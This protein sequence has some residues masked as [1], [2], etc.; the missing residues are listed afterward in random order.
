MSINITDAIFAQAER[1]PD[2][3]AVID[4]KM[5]VNYRALCHGVRLAAQQFQNA[6]W[7]AGNIA[8]ISLSGNPALHLVCVLALARMGITQVSM[9]PRDLAPLR[10][11]RMERLGIT[12]LIVNN[13][14]SAAGINVTTVIPD[15]GWLTAPHSTAVEDIRASGGDAL[16]IINETSGTTATPK[17]IGISHAAEDIHH[18]RLR[19]ALEYLPGERFLSL[20]SLNFLSALKRTI[21]CLSE[22]GTVTLPPA[23]FSTDQLLQWIELHHVTFMTCVPL[24]L[25]QI[26]HDLQG[27]SQCLPFMRILRCS[28][29]TL[30]VSAVIDVCK[31]ISPNVYIDYGCTE[32]GTATIATPAMLEA[33]PG[34]IGRPLAGIEFEVVDDDG[35]LVSTGAHGHVRVRGPGVGNC[36]LHAPEP[37]QSAAFR[38]GWF[39]PGDVVV[40][41][42]DGFV[43]LKGRSDEVM[44]FDGIMVG[45][46]E[47]ESVLRQHPAV[48]E[49][50]AFA[51]PS[52]DHQ[53]IP[54]AA[55][56]S[57]LPLQV[58]NL[59][60][61][62]TALLG[63][64]SPRIFLQFDEIP[65]NPMG[66]ILRRRV[67]ELA[68]QKL[69]K[70]PPSS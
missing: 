61:F 23:N 66:K 28:S 69:K 1:D 57:A 55:I 49:V 52:R 18:K 31:R 13:R 58:D 59:Q 15:P 36:Y 25:H 70:Q 21:Y 56:V 30:P 43:F 38:D 63:V 7:K 37:G 22:G 42:D 17:A 62:C 64:R 60:R 32:I 27:D 3:I 24:H 53:D 47:I 4:A 5:S 44:N 33:N 51:L 45:P 35:K 8:G 19:T 40:V 29:A 2:A 9:P 6:G 12:R 16:W 68:I 39:Y 67:T 20:V 50:A 14:R 41:D 10:K 26:L 54:A 11:A 34:T 65:K 46:A 48:Q